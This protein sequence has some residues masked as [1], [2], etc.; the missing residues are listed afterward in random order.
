MVLRASHCGTPAPLSTTL[1]VTATQ[2]LTHLSRVPHSCPGHVPDQGCMRE[3]RH[4]GAT[5]TSSACRSAWP[6][7]WAAGE[8][9]WLQR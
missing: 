9:G 8:R 4:P 3:D 7:R 5:L 2:G 1:L 6:R